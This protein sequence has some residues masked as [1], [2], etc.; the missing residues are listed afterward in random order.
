MIGAVLGDCLGAPVEC[1]YWFGIT[2][3]SVRKHFDAYKENGSKPVENT[4]QSLM[5]YT[6]DTA[7]ARQVA[8]SLVDKKSLDVTDLAKRFVAEH[9]NEPWR[10]YGASV[11]DVFRKLEKTSF[12]SENEVFKPASEQ[13]NGSGSYGNG[14]AMR[15]HPI[16]LFGTNISEVEEMAERQAKLTHSHNDAIMGSILQATGT[17]QRN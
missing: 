3:K 4:S 14:A 12:S 17:F 6:D 9:K 11:G 8:N 1:S 5:Q 2:N 10:G 15:V 7:M 13:F 16:G